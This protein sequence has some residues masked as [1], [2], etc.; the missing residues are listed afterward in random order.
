MRFGRSSET[1]GDTPEG[2]RHLQPGDDYGVLD[3]RVRIAGKP[4]IHIPPRTIA[5]GDTTKV[6]LVP[7]RQPGMDDAAF[8][9]DAAQAERELAALKALLEQAWR[10]SA[11]RPHPQ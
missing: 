3:H 10:A 8:E 2:D 1:P 7:F 9:R 11:T 6:E 5:N 4:E